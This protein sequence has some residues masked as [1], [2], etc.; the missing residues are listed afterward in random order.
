MLHVEI[1]DDTCEK[2]EA[3][4]Y[5]IAAGTELTDVL[6]MISVLHPSTS[7]IHIYIKEE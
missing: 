2:D 6:T 4:I 5:S 3:H 1:V 7:E